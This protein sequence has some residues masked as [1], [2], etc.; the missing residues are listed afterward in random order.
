MMSYELKN[1][2]VHWNHGHWLNNK[3]ERHKR[4]NASSV[5]FFILNSSPNS[6]AVD[7]LEWQ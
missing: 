7:W 4:V 1:P 5:D 2:K 6:M 3:T